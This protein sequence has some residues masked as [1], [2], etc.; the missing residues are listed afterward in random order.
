MSRQRC[1]RKLL[2]RLQ[3]SLWKDP[4][5]AGT[6]HTRYTLNRQAPAYTTSCYRQSLHQSSPADNFPSSLLRQSSNPITE[7]APVQC[8]KL[9]I[10]E[11]I[12]YVPLV[13]LPPLQPYSSNAKFFQYMDQ[14]TSTPGGRVISRYTASVVQANALVSQIKGP[15]IGFDLEWRPHGAVNVSLVQICDE[16]QIL[17]IHICNM[18]GCAPENVELT[19]Q[20]SPML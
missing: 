9:E 19:C 5:R 15:V 12:P 8:E 13:S 14:R 2:P 16:D 18:K 3:T 11:T 4:I 10:T 1:I 7:A 20:N 6:L 17:L